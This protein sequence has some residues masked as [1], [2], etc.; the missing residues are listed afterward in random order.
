[1]RD[2][3]EHASDGCALT[4]R[5]ARVHSHAVSVEQLEPSQAPGGV[6]GGAARL[7]GV[8]KESQAIPG[9]STYAPSEAEVAW[10]AGL[11]EGEGC[12]SRWAVVPRLQ[13]SL[14]TTDEDV[15]QRFVAIVGVGMVAKRKTRPVKDHWKASWM[16]QAG[17]GDAEV[18]FDLFAPWLSSRR[19]ARFFEVREQR[20][21]YER[22]LPAI[23]SEAASRSAR[24]R[25][26]IGSGQRET[27]W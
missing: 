5:G 15:L 22:Q 14:E 1:L 18:V 13:A 7:G 19:R 25:W 8:P 10:A 24:T 6:E 23:R 17:G 3:H 4:S 27:L 9:S 11:F 20:R 26:G 2:G 16:W 21:E 12:F